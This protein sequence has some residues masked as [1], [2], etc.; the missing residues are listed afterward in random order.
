[1]KNQIKVWKGVWG[2][3]LQLIFPFFFNIDFKLKT[4]KNQDK[5]PKSGEKIKQN[6]FSVG[7]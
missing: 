3:I 6:I 1:M 2:F 7:D 4:K 5:T